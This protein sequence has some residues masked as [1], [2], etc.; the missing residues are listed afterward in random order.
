MAAAKQV[1]RIGPFKDFIAS[2]VRVG[3]LL[4]LSGQVSVDGR[5]EVVGK[6]D[7][8]A[9]VRQAY[10]N[11]PEV[12][13]QFGVSMGDVVDEMWLVT[14]MSGWLWVRASEPEPPY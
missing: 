2:G 13:D 12:L 1:V 3:D 5:G 10:A 14:D 8:G 9:Q 6:G 7:I 4:T 11:V